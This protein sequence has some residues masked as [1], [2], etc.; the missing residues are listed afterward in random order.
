MEWLKKIWKAWK[1]F[2]HALGKAQTMVLLTLFYFI[3]L[4]PT[5]FFF[6][7]FGKSALPYRGTNPETFW[8]N[9]PTSARGEAQYFQQY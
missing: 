2:A 1:S 8:I 5:A 7:L 9:K 6:R 3:V 4:G